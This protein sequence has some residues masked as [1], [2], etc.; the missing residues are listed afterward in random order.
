MNNAPDC[1]VAGTN[2]GSY[3][4]IT[5]WPGVRGA[6]TWSANRDATAGYALVD[7]MAAHPRTMP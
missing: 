2:C 7:T 6:M 5:T 1:L 4:P 3:R